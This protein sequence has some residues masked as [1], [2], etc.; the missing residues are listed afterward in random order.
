MNRL[1]VM[2]FLLAF[3][4]AV[5]AM[6]TNV[7]Q[8]CAW[9][10]GTLE[11][12]PWR[13]KTASLVR[14]L[15]SKFRSWFAALWS[16]RLAF[17]CVA[18]VLVAVLAAQ[19]A[20]D[21]HGLLTAIVVPVATLKANRD[22]LVR[23]AAALQGVDG[24]F[25]DD[26]TRAAFDAKMS[27]IDGVDAQIRAAADAPAPQPAVVD[28]Q[29]RDRAIAEERAR[30]IAIREAVTRAQKMNPGVQGLN[31]DAMIQRGITIE[32]ARSEVFAQLAAASDAVRTDGQIAIGDDAQD[33]W[34]RG[35]TNW[36]LVRSGMANVV[37]QAE[38][39]DVST[40][41]PGEFRGMSLLDLARQ[42]LERHGRS[43]RG[44][45][46]MRL[47][48]EALTMRDGGLIAQ[49]TSDFAT[50]LENVMN[51]VLQ[52]QYAIT[53]DT[54]RRFCAEGSVPDFRAAPRYRMGNFSVLDALT[55]LG[56]F[57]NKG[58]NDAEKASIT[59]ATKGNIVT[60]SRQVIV[61]DDLN[62]FT[63]VPARLGRAAAL[64]V[65]T[66]VYALLAQ[67]A[68]LGPT[69]FDGLTL[70]HATHG[71]ITT[72]AALSAAAIDADRVAMASQK[73]IGG[74]DYADLRPAVLVIG[75]GLGGQAR[76]INQ[77]Q[78]D[79]DNIANKAQNRPNV[80]VGLF[81]DVVDSPRVTAIST[82]RR[83]LFADPMVAPVLE[84]AFVDGQTAPV[85]ETRDGWRMD[86][87]EM[88]VRFDY[89]TAATDYR[90]SVTNAGV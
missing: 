75:V 52:A 40:L 48:S 78:Y 42:T 12:E 7:F 47:V 59:A 22:Q 41:A 50:L 3:F 8:V 57:K 53:P 19:F 49:G 65:E 39:S 21:H 17:A 51:K 85:L 30:G 90:G 38:K 2:P 56:E 67:N 11:I 60:I 33:K 23:E 26:A 55:D 6:P 58:I 80:V 36:L 18:L 77:S 72:G 71:N 37:A 76:V 69:I 87:A 63:Q 89:G 1:T 29:A 10:A 81:R 62:F 74:N 34:L 27:E 84:V 44:L 35:A 16:P 86:G 88:K 46:K 83:Y 13:Q 25:K 43:F 15:A 14:A 9:G 5:A 70:F 73:E 66:D 54:W 4:A 32:A 45:D 68:G 28:V 24:G 61:N 82:T 31:A 64:S 20:A 79:P